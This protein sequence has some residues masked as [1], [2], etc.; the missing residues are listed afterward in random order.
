M[1]KDSRT[2][3]IICL[4]LAAATLAVYWP[5]TGH[6]FVDYDDSDYVT[7]NPYV[8]AGLSVK[9]VAWA[10]GSDVARNWH[11]VTMLSHMADCQFYGMKPWGIT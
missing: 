3:L 10:W 2:N 5:V 4:C 9:S 1:N 7:K 6:G 11:P 8:Q